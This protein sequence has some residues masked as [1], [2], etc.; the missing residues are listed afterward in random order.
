MTDVACVIIMPKLQATYQEAT[1]TCVASTG[2]N[3]TAAEMGILQL[4]TFRKL[5]KKK[6]KWQQQL[7]QNETGRG[8][9]RF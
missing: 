9:E 4:K 3:F 5:C 2:N 1:T 6:P 7:R 8:K